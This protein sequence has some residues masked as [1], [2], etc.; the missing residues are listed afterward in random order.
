M[1]DV[2]IFDLRMQINAHEYLIRSLCIMLR[3]F[4]DD[5]QWDRIWSLSDE[6]TD[7][8]IG[9]TGPMTLEERERRLELSQRA[10]KKL[11]T[12]M[13]DMKGIGRRA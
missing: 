10:T 13:A 7:P 3:Q 4:Y 1:H 2:E 5:E 12:I 9:G 11:T 6:L 8:Q